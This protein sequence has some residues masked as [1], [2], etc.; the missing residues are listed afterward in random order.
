MLKFGLDWLKSEVQY[1]KFEGGR[2][3]PIK[4]ELHVTCDAHF[5]NCRG[6]L[7]KSHVGNFGAD[8]LRLSR[9]IVDTKKKKKKAARL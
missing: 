6:F 1:V 9:V 4:G 5:R 8:W 7:D 3:P 2:R